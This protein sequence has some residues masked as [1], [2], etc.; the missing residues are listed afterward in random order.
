MIESNFFVKIIFSP[1]FFKKIGV[2]YNIAI[3]LIFFYFV[4][5]LLLNNICL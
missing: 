2:V 1:E 4:F 3:N 5:L